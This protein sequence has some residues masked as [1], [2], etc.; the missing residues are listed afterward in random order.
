MKENITVPKLVIIG[1]SAYDTN[2]FI[3]ED[4]SHFFKTNYGGAGT[5]SSVPASL[6]YRV[7]LVSNAGEDFNVDK[8]KKFNIDLRGFHTRKDEKTSRFYNILKTR[9]GQER[10]IAAEY[11]ERLTATFDDIPKEFL[12][13]KYFYISTM[14][15]KNQKQII[16]KLRNHNPNV[17]IGVDTF[18][19]YANSDETREVFDLADIAFVDKEFSN[20]IQCKSKTKVIKLG[21]TG[22][23]DCLNGVFMNLIANGYSNEV[24]LKKAIE[25]ATLSIK[26]FG[27][28]H[29]KDRIMTERDEAR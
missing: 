26:D 22:A 5:Y 27:I 29:I 18:E 25:I 16:E 2:R 4:G 24:A 14:L 3:G 11:N 6:F 9:D 10:E 23:G 20:L 13:A 21:K 19:E 7:G 12:K 1:D 15:P 8:L 28:L 17:I